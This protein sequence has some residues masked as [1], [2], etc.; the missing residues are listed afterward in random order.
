MCVCVS[1]FILQ[2]SDYDERADYD[3]DGTN[4]SSEEEEK[5]D[6]DC[7]LSAANTRFKANQM[8]K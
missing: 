6:T 1:D 5:Y 8:K 2:G 3:D 4:I 7:D